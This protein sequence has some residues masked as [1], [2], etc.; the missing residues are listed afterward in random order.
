MRT[1]FLQVNSNF[2]GI[3]ENRRHTPYMAV[4]IFAVGQ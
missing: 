1:L 4:I 3:A 2:C